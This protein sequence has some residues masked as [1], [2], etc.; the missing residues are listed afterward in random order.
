MD[1]GTC[2]TTKQNMI[3]ACHAHWVMILMIRG[4][5]N[6][7]R[8]SRRK[9]WPQGFKTDRRSLSST[10]LSVS[11]LS[12]LKASSKRF[13]SAASNMPGTAPLPLEAGWYWLVVR[14]AMVSH[15]Q[16][17]H[18]YSRLYWIISGMLC[19]WRISCPGA[20]RDSAPDV[21]L[22][23]KSH[24]GGP[25]KSCE[26]ILKIRGWTV[27]NVG[28][29]SRS[30]GRGIIICSLYSLNIQ[31]GRAVGTHVCQLQSNR[32]KSL[33]IWRQNSSPFTS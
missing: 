24:L 27:P 26:K 23:E 22:G 28:P 10:K 32:D 9:Q 7:P 6:N 1:H 25:G 2:E 33:G 8:I 5:T 17:S 11:C 13:V 30:Q 4:E 14:S 3:S 19:W 16:K 15:G 18:S 31:P 21:I 20:Y 29:P 12:P